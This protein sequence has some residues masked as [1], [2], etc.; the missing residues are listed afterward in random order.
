M[1]SNCYDYGRDIF[2]SGPYEWKSKG[3]FLPGHLF[4]EW[5][6]LTFLTLFYCVFLF[7]Y[8]RSMST[9]KN[10]TIGI[11]KW[12]LGTIILAVVELFFRTC[13]YF[14]WNKSGFRS[15]NILYIW[16]LVGVLKGSISRCLLVM[17]SLGWGVIRDTLGDSMRKIIMLGILYGSVAFLRDATEIWYVEEVQVLSAEQEKKMLYE[18]YDLF[19]I[20]TFVTAIID[21]TFYMWILDSLNSTMQYLEN[22]NQSMKLKRYLRLRLILLFSILFGV[23]WSIFGIVD[24]T[25]DNA[26]LSE[27]KE[28][29][30]R[31]MWAVNYTFVLVSIALLW[32]P[33]PRAKEFAYVMELP[34]IGEDMVLDTNIGSAD[35]YDDDD[36]VNVSYSDVEKDGR[37]TIDDAVPS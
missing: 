4:E 1:I 30:V 15:D 16:I 25:S 2:V 33:D 27:G 34:S 23:M 14:E 10:S 12:I 9:N 32:K 20:L 3:G 17:V 26:I 31:A 21:V 13:D 29:V 5:H 35:D 7:W 28:W 8:A 6:F 11:Q 36:G 37:F 19:E 24:A 22:M 18:I